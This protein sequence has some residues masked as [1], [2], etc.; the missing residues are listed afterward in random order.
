MVDIPSV[1]AAHPFS[2]L[3]AILTSAPKQPD[4]SMK[5]FFHI[6]TYDYSKRIGVSLTK[7]EHNARRVHHGIYLPDRLRILL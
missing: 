7:Y 4:G 6:T 1:V 3:F 5:S 2:V